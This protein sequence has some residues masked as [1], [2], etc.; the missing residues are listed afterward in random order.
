MLEDAL[1][2]SFLHCCVTMLEARPMIVVALPNI[3]CWGV[4]KGY[5]GVYIG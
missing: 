1:P 4:E 2:L 3:I 5:T